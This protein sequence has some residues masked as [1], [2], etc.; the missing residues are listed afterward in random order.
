MAMEWLP[1]PPDGTMITIGFDGSDVSD[2]TAL[3]A[4]THNGCQFTPRY[5]PDRRPTI[6]N[7]ADWGGETPRHEVHA[8]VDEMFRRYNVKLAYCDPFGWA[9]EVGEWFSKYGDKTVLEWRTNRNR[10]MFEEIRRFETDLATG[11]IKHDGCPLTA[12]A[13]ANAVKAA[14]PGDIYILAKPAGQLHRKIDPVIASILAHT[15]AA[16]AHE[17]GWGQVRPNYAYTW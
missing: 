14:R 4:E 9:S 10:L 7:P 2:W 6:W 17:Q 15:A 11:R 3:R 8:A 12:Q 16:D 1:N 5:G 13:M